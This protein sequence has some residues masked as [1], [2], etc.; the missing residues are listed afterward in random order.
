M[1]MVKHRE[2]RI[3]AP[4]R[5]GT[6]TVT[7]LLLVSLAV[8]LTGCG[9]GETS[10]GKD[11]G[12]ALEHSMKGYELYSWETGGEWRFSLLVGTNRLKS[13]GEIMSEDVSVHGVDAIIAE[14]EKLPRGEEVFWRQMEGLSLPPEHIIESIMESC[15]ASGIWP[16][17]TFDTFSD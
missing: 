15:E 12:V 4:A 6:L 2:R 10:G 11:P 7:L 17:I 9:S 14:L 1:D 8:S 5:C 16:V 3:A 13:A